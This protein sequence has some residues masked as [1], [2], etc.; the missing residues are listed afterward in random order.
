[1]KCCGLEKQQ[2]PLVCASIPSGGGTTRA[3]S[4]QREHLEANASLTLRASSKSLIAKRS[5][6]ESPCCTVGSATPSSLTTCSDRSCICG[7]ILLSSQ[8]PEWRKCQILAQE[9][10]SRDVDSY[11]FWDGSLKDVYQSLSWLPETG[12]AGSDLN[13]SSGFVVS[14]ES[15]SWYSRIRIAPQSRSS[16]RTLWPSFRF[17]VADGTA[18]AAAKPSKKQSTECKEEEKKQLKM[19]KLRLRPTKEQRRQLE[20]WSHAARRTYNETVSALNRREDCHN[21]F[22]LR[23]RFVTAKTQDGTVNNFFANKP[24]MLEVPKAVRKGAVDDAIAA[25]KAAFTNKA[26]GNIQHFQMGFRRRKQQDL[27]GWSLTLE[28][29][30][31]CKK[32]D[33]LAIFGSYLGDMR[34]SDTKQLHKLLP[35]DHP[36]FD[37]KLQKDRFGDYFLLLPKEANIAPKKPVGSEGVVAVDPGIRKWLT[38][39]SPDQQEAVMVAPRFMEAI[40]PILYKLECLQSESD[41][42]AGKSRRFLEEKIV[43]LRKILFYRKKELQ[44]QTA[45]YMVANYDTILMPKLNTKALVST[46]NPKGLKAKVTRR[47]MM[48]TG[49]CAFFDHLKAKCQEKG[50][51]F[52]HVTEHYTSQT[53]HLCGCLTKTSSETRRCRQCGYKGDRDII[54]A[55]NILLR[56]VRSPQDKLS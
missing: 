27:R 16:E 24:W 21:K 41:R 4:R 40:W 18:S 54:G 32:G 43:R 7:P 45:A 19:Y 56:A 10:T 20:Q 51:T 3:S 48:N 28:K 44:H 55:L 47:E 50:A 12:C 13:S 5:H 38:M 36:D 30:N 11:A 34:Y 35:G 25:W 46:S 39:Y 37:C 31:V 29:A 52:M 49:H 1:M 53:C 14:E 8:P 2:R 17:T 9:S 33:N 6:L 26:N 42:H 15:S 22:K 23:N